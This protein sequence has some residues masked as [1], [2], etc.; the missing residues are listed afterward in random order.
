MLLFRYYNFS[1][2]D[3]QAGGYAQ[4]I[5]TSNG[6]HVIYAVI[7]GDLGYP[8]GNGISLVQRWRGRYFFVN[9]GSQYGRSNVPYLEADV[10][11]WLDEMG[12]F[13]GLL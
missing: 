6:K 13:Y 7:G 8:W 3:Y 2:T 10:H 1:G 5:N 4:L 11:A 12:V 9:K